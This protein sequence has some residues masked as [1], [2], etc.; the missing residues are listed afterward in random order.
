MVEKKPIVVSEEVGLFLAKK[1]IELGLIKE[2]D[3]FGF[4]KKSRVEKRG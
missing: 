4:D 1:F 2:S 3:V